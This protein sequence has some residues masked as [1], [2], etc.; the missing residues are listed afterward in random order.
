MSKKP[1]EIHA[2]LTPIEKLLPVVYDDGAML[3]SLEGN[4]LCGETLDD[5]RG[6]IIRG[7]MEATI[8]GMGF[9]KACMMWI[10]V[11]VCIASH[12]GELVFVKKDDHT[13]NPFG[14]AD[15]FRKETGRKSNLESSISEET[16]IAKI[17]MLNK[18]SRFFS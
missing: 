8:H 5:F 6:R 17:K 12:E 16:D 10:N 11:N 2:L 1:S 15:E 13:D 9:C 14:L 4:C 18:M 7:G 3:T